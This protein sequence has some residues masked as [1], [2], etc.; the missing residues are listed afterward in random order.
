MAKANV[1]RIQLHKT[2]KEMT[3]KQMS[4]EIQQLMKALRPEEFKNAF[5]KSL[6]GWL[7]GLPEGK[8]K[9]KL[10]EDLYP[11][12]PEEVREMVTRETGFALADIPAPA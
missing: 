4:Q 1:K 7:K 10:L 2:E 11:Q 5:E 8:Q 6:M 3:A 12:L 9:L